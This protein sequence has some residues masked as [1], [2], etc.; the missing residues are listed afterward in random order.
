MK[1]DAPSQK[2]MEYC[3][4]LNCSCEPTHKTKH[5]L[6]IMQKTRNKKKINM[7]SLFIRT[8]C[9]LPAQL[10]QLQLN[11]NIT[12]SKSALKVMTSLYRVYSV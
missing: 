3:K 12:N 7:P 11:P 10:C 2:Q 4:I 1:N 6:S 9:V 5:R 8:C